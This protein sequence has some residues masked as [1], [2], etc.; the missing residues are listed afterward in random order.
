M[1]IYFNGQV[2]HPGLGFLKNTVAAYTFLQLH[3]YK[4]LVQITFGGGT[5][6]LEH[7]WS[8]NFSPEQHSI[9]RC[10]PGSNPPTQLCG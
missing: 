6:C 2:A 9:S 5:F 7:I 1:V 4:Q 3:D 10:S 8:P